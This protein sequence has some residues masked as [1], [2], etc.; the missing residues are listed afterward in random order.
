M[1]FPAPQNQNGR[2]ARDSRNFP[3]NKLIGHE[4]AQNQ[5]SLTAKLLD[6]ANQPRRICA[7]LGAHGSPLED[8]VHS[9]GQVLHDKIGL[10]RP[11]L[12]MQFIF[13]AAVARQNQ[14]SAPANSVRQLD[15]AIAIPHDKRTI[16]AQ[17][18]L[19]CGLFQQSRQWLSAIAV[20]LLRM[21]AIVVT[22]HAS[23]GRG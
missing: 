11:F 19:P 14:H 17:A 10:P 21:R 20:V 1:H 23:P 13:A 16:E 6:D 5:N 18:V 7:A 8:G 4:I 22:I 2:F 12:A 3:E 9:F 15:V